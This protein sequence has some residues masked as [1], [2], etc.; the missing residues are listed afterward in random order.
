MRNCKAIVYPDE[1]ILPTALMDQLF[2]WYGSVPRYVINLALARFKKTWKQ[3]QGGETHCVLHICSHPSG[4]LDKF[5]VTFASLRVAQAV[6]NRIEEELA[7][8]AAVYVD[9]YSSH[10]LSKYCKKAEA[11]QSV[12]FINEQDFNIQF[13]ATKRQT[14]RSYKEVDLR[15]NCSGS[16]PIK[17]S[18]QLICCLD[19]QIFF[20][21]MVSKTHPIKHQGIHKALELVAKSKSCPKLYF[22]VWSNIYLTYKHQPY[23]TKGS[24]VFRGNLSGVV[25]VLMITIGGKMMVRG[26]EEQPTLPFPKKRKKAV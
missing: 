3:R 10:T 26:E 11:F 17:N 18:H 1:Q 16:R 14:F 6:I 22:V 23:H 2:K 12:N 5:C 7:P 13:A 21:V 25:R 24:S 8:I 9:C 20:Q 15:T 4:S 19:Q